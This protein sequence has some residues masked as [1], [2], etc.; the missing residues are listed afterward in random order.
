MIFMPKT[1][2][3]RDISTWS[4]MLVILLL[5]ADPVLSHFPLRLI[6]WD[7]FGYYL[8]LPQIFI[9]GDVYLHDQVHMDQI[10]ETYH[11][12]HFKYQF[13]LLENGN[14]VIQY[15][16]GVALMSLP[17]FAI[18]HLFAHL[19][20]YPT[21]GY[22]LPYA[23]AFLIGNYCYM[24]LGVLLLRKVLLHFF[25]K[26]ITAFMLIIICLGTNYFA[27][28][29][30]NPG[31]SHVFLFPLSCL[32]IL[33]TIKWYEKYQTKHLYGIA[34]TVA[35]IILV[36]P[37]DGLMVLIPLLWG[38][39]DKKSL[40]NRFE[41]IKTY[42]KPLLKAVVLAFLICSLQMLYWKTVSGHFILNSYR[43][44]EEGLYLDDPH[45]VRFLF[46]FRNGW[47]IYTPIMIGMFAGFFIRHP[48]RKVWLLSIGLFSCLILYFSASWSTWWYGTSF[49]QRTL[50]QSYPIF[51]I[52]LGYFVKW[53]AEKLRRAIILIPIL[54]GLVA[55]NYFQSY[56]FKSGVLHGSRMTSDYYVAIFGKLNGA[57]GA[58]ELLLI[59][60][61]YPVFN[62]ED[63]TLE[64]RYSLKENIDCIDSVYQD[65][66]YGQPLKFPFGHST[67][68]YYAWYKVDVDLFI[69]RNSDTSKLIVVA[70][71]I[72]NCRTYGAMYQPIARH[73]NF[74]PDEWFHM[75]FMYLTPTIRR[76]SDQFET[77]V[78]S[79]NERA[80]YKNLRVSVYQKK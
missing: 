1:K 73:E 48:Q 63:H 72:Q 20:D 41:M 66:E 12:A 77:F 29:I 13:H 75:S 49:S 74:K 78:W 52:P 40:F 68:E 23:W 47:L 62:V 36:R 70:R 27:I 53:S 5:L 28:H 14:Y 33:L 35:L 16:G 9:E 80:F 55:L 30:A 50:I 19:L 42:F 56:Q 32:L 57:A 39:H 7:T 2:K 64:K 26:G 37:L 22:S 54:V 45:L 58:H 4:A 24:I 65:H 67:D 71:M 15:S 51:A 6:A 25:S 11:P 43:N 31:L 61:D 34:T 44:P 3:W 10:F 18:G 17:F 59:D 8:Y 79:Q 60:R 46:S 21:D 38:I 76:K 69:P